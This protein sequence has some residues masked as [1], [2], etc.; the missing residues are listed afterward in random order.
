MGHPPYSKAEINWILFYKLLGH[1]LEQIE[2]LHN[3]RFEDVPRTIDAIQTKLKEVKHANS[4]QEEDG[5]RIC[6]SRL[7]RYLAE[8]IGEFDITLRQHFHLR[9]LPDGDQYLLN[10]Y[11]M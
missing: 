9:R 2:C 1:S 6:L 11:S 3:A 5:N 10:K 7:E 8:S 4:L